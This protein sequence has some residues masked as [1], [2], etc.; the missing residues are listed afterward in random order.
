[1]GTFKMGFSLFT[2]IGLEVF[3]YKSG[4]RPTLHFSSDLLEKYLLKVNFSFN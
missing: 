2:Y 1:M 4:R 3:Q